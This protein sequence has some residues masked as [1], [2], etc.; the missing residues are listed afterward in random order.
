ML[1]VFSAFGSLQ[2][3]CDEVLLYIA[4][5][6]YRVFIGPVLVPANIVRSSGLLAVVS[7]T[8]LHDVFLFRYYSWSLGRVSSGVTVCL[9]DVSAVSSSSSAVVFGARRAL[10]IGTLLWTSFSSMT[11]AF[12]WTCNILYG[13][14]VRSWSLL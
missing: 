10:C 8:S 1:L 6:F 11:V 2:V 13:P 14:G 3:S 9:F 5:G 7:Y 4:P 12:V